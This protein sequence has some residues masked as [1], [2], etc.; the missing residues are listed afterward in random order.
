MGRKAFVKIENKRFYIEE[1]LLPEEEE[2][3]QE[4]SGQVEFKFSEN[5]ILAEAEYRLSPWSHGIHDSS[6]TIEYD[7]KGRMIRNAYCVTHGGHTDISLSLTLDTH[8][9]ARYNESPPS[10]T[11]GADL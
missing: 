6:G 11:A 3:E 7:E 5:G 9:P 1:D 10:K 8:P 2:Y 4:H